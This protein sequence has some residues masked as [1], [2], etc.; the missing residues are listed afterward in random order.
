MIKD[1]VNL[2]FVNLTDFCTK[3]YV[4]TYAPKRSYPD[5]MFPS[6][7]AN[8]TEGLEETEQYST[9]AFP[10]YKTSALS[11]FEFF[12]SPFAARI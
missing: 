12:P 10:V 5:L 9:N 4:L 6:S 1:E 8:S 11:A 2:N 7:Y 3:Q